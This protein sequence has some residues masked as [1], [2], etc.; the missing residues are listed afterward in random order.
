MKKIKKYWLLILSSILFL[1]SLL[2][3][4]LTNRNVKILNDMNPSYYYKERSS[5]SVMLPS[6]EIAVLYFRNNHAK[7]KNSYRYDTIS[8]CYAMVMAIQSYARQHDIEITRS[9]TEMV[10]ELRL[11]NFLYE[12][13][14]KTDETGDADLE[15]IQDRR[16]YVN[17]ASK[18]VGWMGF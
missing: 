5:V 8:D 2:F 1:I 18:M 17:V 6:D 3:F 12:I 13:G 11:H 16:W 14:Y 10:G 7:I 9:L 4:L 15:Y